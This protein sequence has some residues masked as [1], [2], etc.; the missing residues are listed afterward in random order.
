MEELVQG[1]VL[2][3]PPPGSR[4]PTSRFSWCHLQ[5]S[6]LEWTTAASVWTVSVW[7][8]MDN[9]LTSRKE[10]CSWSSQLMAETWTSRT[11][12][13]PPPPPA[14]TW[15][16]ML[17]KDCALPAPLC[18]LLIFSTSPSVQSSRRFSGHTPFSLSYPANVYFC[19]CATSETLCW[20][21]S[22][23]FWSSSTGTCY[24]HR[25]GTAPV[26]SCPPNPSPSQPSRRH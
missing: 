15:T 18:W 9:D 21:P 11:E 1:Q 6:C 14:G 19:T 4:G 12:L 7:S 20:F 25:P 22:G 26:C 13:G 5:G 2:V 17:W 16:E 10:P 8:L 23:C 24:P 3:V